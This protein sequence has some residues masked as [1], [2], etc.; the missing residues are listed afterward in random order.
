M[1]NQGQVQT[2]HLARQAFIYIRQSSLKQV[3]R[4][5]GSTARQY[6][7]KARA[8]DLGWRAD[9]LVIVDQDQAQSGSSSTE[10]MGFQW[11]VAEVGLGHAG[12]VLSL[13]ASRLARSSSVSRTR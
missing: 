2:E 13:E 4:N 11:L 8:Q 7:L 12:A 1:N 6:D 3:Q 10:R 9:Q 5:V